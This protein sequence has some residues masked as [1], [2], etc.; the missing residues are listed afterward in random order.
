MATFHKQTKTRLS[1]AQGAVTFEKFLTP[2]S[3]IHGGQKALTIELTGQ[4][5]RTYSITLYG[6]ETD[7]LNSV[8]EE[9]LIDQGYD[10]LE[11]PHCGKKCKPD[12]KRVNGTIVYEVHKCKSEYELFFTKRSFEIDIDGSL[13]E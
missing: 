9:S 5:N 1:A 7:Q 2:V 10:V 3:A 4:D 8:L 11:C 12:A 13:V 6:S